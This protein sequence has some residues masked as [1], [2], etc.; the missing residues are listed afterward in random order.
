MEFEDIL[1]DKIAME[2][3]M[4]RHFSTLTGRRIPPGLSS[5]QIWSLFAK[6][7]TKLL[8]HCEQEFP[9][10]EDDSADGDEGE[11]QDHE[12]DYEDDDDDEIDGEDDQEEQDLDEDEENDQEDEDEDEEDGDEAD[13]EQEGQSEDYDQFMNEM[14][15]WDEKPA[16]EGDDENELEM[17]MLEEEDEDDDQPKKKS[18]QQSGDA[19]LDAEELFDNLAYGVSRKN[20]ARV[21]KKLI[22]KK[23]WQMRG[24]IRAVERPV[25][26]LLDV[27]VDFETGLQS[28]IIITKE[29]N[30][31]IESIIQQRILD[32]V[33]DDRQLPPPSQHRID[34]QTKSIPDLDFEKDKRGLAGVYE[35][36]YKQL[37]T[38]VDPV[39]SKEEKLKDEIKELFKTVCF[40]I[41]NMSRFN[42][43][44]SNAFVARDRHTNGQVV[45]DEKVPVVVSSRIVENKKSFKD[46]HDP[47]EKELKSK[48]EMSGAEKKRLQRKI[49]ITKKRVSKLRKEK[50]RQKSGISVADSKLLEKNKSL[51]NKQISDSKVKKTEFTKNSTFFQNLN[52]I[53]NPK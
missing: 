10:Q 27:D 9:G 37:T 1:T 11:D 5:E 46:V 16:P 41:D 4:Q 21:E 25:N 52:K 24:E 19:G 8:D 3:E 15:E 36:E 45:F 6:D 20:I 34:E 42:F 26:A 28:K 30:E 18:K 32:H 33:F 31:K 2:R 40:C 43:T 39:K 7:V 48:V 23:E 13:G 38:G 53:S 12:M 49:K 35:D 47:K 17:K 14:D 51:I 50:E 44:P 29:T 22:E